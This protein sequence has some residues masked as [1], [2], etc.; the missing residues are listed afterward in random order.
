MSLS[1]KLAK[2]L[3]DHCKAG[4]SNPV[5]VGQISSCGARVCRACQNIEQSG[6][7]SMQDTWH[8]STLAVSRQMSE[9][10]CDIPCRPS[11]MPRSSLARPT[12]S[13]S[14]R[15]GSIWQAYTKHCM[16][17]T[18]CSTQFAHPMSRM[19]ATGMTYES[20]HRPILS[21]TVFRP[22]QCQHNFDDRLQKE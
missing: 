5:L 13:S 10:G 9:R 4:T 2:T 6:L 7:G 22:L 15:A 16:H 12:A 1:I 21:D 18:R 19:L 20:R 11:V 17:D 14:G 8:H 3:H